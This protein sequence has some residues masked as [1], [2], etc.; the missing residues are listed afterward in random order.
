MKF[1]LCALPKMSNILEKSLFKKGCLMVR[2][3]RQKQVFCKKCW[4]VKPTVIP[5]RPRCRLW[6]QPIRRFFNPVRMSWESMPAPVLAAKSDTVYG[7]HFDMEEWPAQ[8]T[9]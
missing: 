5:V 6:R 7:M 2:L 4:A 1:T 9:D 8:Q 3:M